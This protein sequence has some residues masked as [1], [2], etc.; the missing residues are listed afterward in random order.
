MIA[1]GAPVNPPIAL[2]SRIIAIIGEIHNPLRSGQ[3]H[4]PTQMG[5]MVSKLRKWSTEARVTNRDLSPSSPTKTALPRLLGIVDAH[6]PRRANYSKGPTL[7]RY[8]SMQS[9]PNTPANDVPSLPKYETP[10]H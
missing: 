4:L 7:I 3:I 10:I 6:V 9:S 2:S 1:R 8:F 5:L